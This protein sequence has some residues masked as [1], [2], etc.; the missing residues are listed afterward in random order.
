MF[1]E[2]P[3]ALDAAGLASVV[4]G[5]A[6]TARRCVANGFDGVEVQ[7][8]QA[9]LLHAFL[10]PGSNLRD[11]AYGGGL[12]G[13]MRL[14][15]EVVAAVRAAFGTAPVLGV[16]LG[17]DDPAQG[18][19]PLDDIVAVARAA[20]R[21]GFRR[22][23]QHDDGRRHASLHRVEASMA[24]SPGH[25]LPVARALRSATSASPSSGS[26]AWSNRSTPSRPSPTVTATWSAVVRGQIADP[27]F[28]AKALGGRPVR[29]C[30]GC[31]QDCIGRVGINRTRA[32]W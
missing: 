16:R 7:A 28:A 5:F 30:L 8:S 11:D 21:H 9:A 29:R 23:R 10:A 20:R 26:V 25:A 13:R 24:M 17:A 22:L 12:A 2:V 1:R 15:L 18:G 32:A 3:V 14:L 4:E 6:A 19:V 27:A 31:N